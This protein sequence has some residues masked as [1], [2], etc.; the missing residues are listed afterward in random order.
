MGRGFRAANDRRDPQP[1]RGETVALSNGGVS[2]VVSTGPFRGGAAMFLFALTANTAMLTIY[3]KLFG[4]AFAA[5]WA[6][7]LT[8]P[9][10]EETPRRPGSS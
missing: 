6:P 1:G 2:F 9:F 10:T 8:A 3:P 7:A 4:Q 5:D